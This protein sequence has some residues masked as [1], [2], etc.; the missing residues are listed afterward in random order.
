MT[1]LV[2]FRYFV[3][4]GHPQNHI[5]QSDVSRHIETVRLL[6][7]FIVSHKETHG[8]ITN[9]LA[10]TLAALGRWQKMTGEDVHKTTNEVLNQILSHYS[11]EGWFREYSGADFGYQ[12]LALDYLVDFKS[13]FTHSGLDQHLEK[14]HIF[15][16]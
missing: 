13:L 16:L 10:V 2:A 3:R 7:N 9:H 14:P 11:T 6:I 1:S 5:S 12:T 15:I 8:V 4:S